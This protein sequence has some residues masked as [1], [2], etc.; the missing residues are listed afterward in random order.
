M[1]CRQIWNS[2]LESTQRL[3]GVTP[4]QLNSTQLNWDCIVYLIPIMSIQEYIFISPHHL[5]SHPSETRD[6]SV[7][8][9]GHTRAIRFVITSNASRKT[10][11]LDNIRKIPLNSLWIFRFFF[12]A[13]PPVS[14]RPMKGRKKCVRNQRFRH[15]AL[16]ETG[17]PW[18]FVWVA[19]MKL[20]FLIRIDCVRSEWQT[21]ESVSLTMQH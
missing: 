5:N 20:A 8:R 14:T 21:C 17:C 15:N 7:E 6:F 9:L 10:R 16:I 13:L 19:V 3:K 11:V 4:F 18:M 2:L 12:F 1:L